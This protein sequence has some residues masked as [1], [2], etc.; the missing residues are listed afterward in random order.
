[1][2]LETVTERAFLAM[3][4]PSV[5]YLLLL[6]FIVAVIVG[7]KYFSQGYLGRNW[8][9]GACVIAVMG[10][11]LIYLFMKVITKFSR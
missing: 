5:V 8:F 1:M 9:T 10:P 11:V 3:K 4:L 6:P 2:A 7:V